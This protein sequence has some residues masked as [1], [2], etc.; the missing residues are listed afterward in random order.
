MSEEG[1]RQQKG[2]IRGK[3]GQKRPKKGGGRGG[4]GGR[5]KRAKG[6]RGFKGEIS[7]EDGAEERR[8]RG[9]PSPSPLF[10]RGRG[11]EKMCEKGREWKNRKTGTIL[12]FPL[13]GAPNGSNKKGESKVFAEWSGRGQQPIIG[14]LWSSK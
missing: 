6:V 8:G 13:Q 1:E 3:R 11:R 10:I 14:I 2:K 9:F 4:P 5:I 12:F 7:K